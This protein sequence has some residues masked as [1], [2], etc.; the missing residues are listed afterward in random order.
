MEL[1]E[2]VENNL[3]DTT[4]PPSI[5]I[6]SKYRLFEHKYN[7]S[8]K[9]RYLCSICHCFVYSESEKVSRCI[10]VNSIR[11]KIITCLPSMTHLSIRNIYSTTLVYAVCLHETIVLLMAISIR[12]INNC[13][14]KKELFLRLSCVFP[15]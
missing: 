3:V 1:N 7:F 10:K 12:K 5:Y 4:L 11:T 9:C 6:Y 13:T 2:Q 15:V 14:Q 8:F